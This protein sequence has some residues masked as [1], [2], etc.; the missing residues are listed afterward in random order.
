MDIFSTKVKLVLLL[1]SCCML[2]MAACW[3]YVKHKQ[4]EQLVLSKT[5]FNVPKDKITKKI[6]PNGM[7]VLLYKNEALP[8]VLVQIAYNVGSAEET[9]GE[10]GLAHLVEHMIFKG[11]DRLSEGDIDTIARKYGASYNAF[12]SYDVTSYYFETNKNN[13]RPFLDMLADCMQNVR[14]DPEH[15][16]SEV[17][18]VVQELN[19]GK[20]NYW[21]MLILKAIELSFA[22]N[23]PYHIPVIG[24]KEDLLNLTA[25]RIKAFYTRHY[26]PDR[27]TLFVVGDIDADEMM[28]SIEEQ[29][30][31]IPAGQK[32]TPTVFPGHGAEVS[33]TSMRFYEDV[34]SE[35]VLLYWSIPGH[36]FEQQHVV[37]M[38][39]GLLGAGQA[40]LLNKLLVDEHK[41]AAS[42]S[43]YALKL[44][45]GGIFCVMIEPLPGKK[46]RCI[47][48]TQEAIVKLAT[49]GVK[50]EEIDRIAKGK[51][52][53]FFNQMINYKS[54]VNDW[55]YS[56][57]ATGDEF[58][59]FD[60][61]N[62]FSSVTTTEVQHF[63]QQYLDPFLMQQLEVLP[64]PADK[65][66]Y[67]EQLKQAA[68]ELDKE[69]LAKHQRTSP[70][71]QPRAANEY[72]NPMP[73]DF[74][75]PQPERIVELANGLTVILLPQHHTPLVSLSCGFKDAAYFESAREGNVLD[76][77]MGLLIE[78]SKNFTKQENVNFF[79][80]RGA[81]Y[82]FSKAGAGM[83]CLASDFDVLLERFMH[84]LQF[85]TFPT[86]ALA[87]VRQIAIDSFVRAKDEPSGLAARL[88]NSAIYKDNAYAWTFD[89][90]I[91]DLSAA[92]PSLLRQLHASLI[93]GSNVVLSVVGDFNADAME[94]S[95]R[96]AF[97]VLPKGNFVSRETLPAQVNDFASINHKLVR[98]QLF[99]MYGKQG[100]VTV[101]DADFLPLKLLS[102][103]SFTSLGSRLFNVRET[104]GLFYTAFG[105]Y[106][107]S[108]G[109]FPGTD[110]V[111]MIINP[112][113]LE[114]AEQAV[115]TLLEEIALHGV[116]EAELTAAKTQ[117]EQNLVGILGQNGRLCSLFNRLHRLGLPYNYYEN[118]LKRVHEMTVEE[119]NAV[120]ARHVNKDGFVRVCVG[121]V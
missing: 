57:F 3:L 58:D 64:L 24:Y 13:W 1:L 32:P 70:K 25:D 113:N 34:S 44:M 121:P 50:V 8:K 43:A 71:E 109:I 22:P 23:H 5:P 95:I 82:S 45:E 96:S 73:L 116:T 88:L 66:G 80:Q 76:L 54:L 115:Y 38:V 97:Q 17:K 56:Y 42:A 93:T 21:R 41:V 83:S 98:D 108:A 49:D 110:S 55:L 29:F 68:A 7:Q 39:E 63:A 37:D 112:E 75:L 10:R 84:I 72:P 15:L 120:A 11:T 2:L 31:A 20:D 106:A 105:S 53:G 16:A 28:R 18:A 104:T 4:P 90:A 12:T 52:V 77:M 61:V 47:Q 85:P 48:L 101:H 46:D 67:K 103:I 118:A 6:L 100:N 81:G 102:T 78:G 19:M 9:S 74:V 89:E 91:A 33:A 14:F 107:E 94:K 99:L 51:V 62:K 79:E 27:A 69:I 40:S 35:H 117:Y 60:C 86:D 119:V 92:T 26:S 111:G 87:K 36:K 30:S 59:V 65:K 114:K